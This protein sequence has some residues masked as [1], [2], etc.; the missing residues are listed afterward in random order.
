MVDQEMAADEAAQS[1]APEGDA[2]VADDAPIAD[3]APAAADNPVTD[4]PE[5]RT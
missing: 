1:S 5:T 3:D 2:P 4:A